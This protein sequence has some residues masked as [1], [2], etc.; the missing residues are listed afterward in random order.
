MKVTGNYLTFDFHVLFLA[1]QTNPNQSVF[2][3]REL[4]ANAGIPANVGYYGNN[5]RTEL[6]QDF[7][8]E[9]DQERKREREQLYHDDL[10]RLL[11]KYEQQEEDTMILADELQRNAIVEGAIMQQELK[12]RAN[13]PR[14]NV[15]WD[16]TTAE[17]GIEKRRLTLP[18]L[19][20]RR[21]RF[22]ISKRSPAIQ[23]KRD[24]DAAGA[25]ISQDL[26]TLFGEPSAD[27]KDRLGIHKVAKKSDRSV[28]SLH[29]SH[30]A[31]DEHSHEHSSHESHDHACENSEEDMDDDDRKKKRSTTTV[32]PTKP[33]I[34]GVN[35][36]REEL[37]LDQLITSPGS[38]V[39]GPSGLSGYDE[40]TRISKKSIQ[41]SKYFGLDR[42]KKSVD[43]WY[44]PPYR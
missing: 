41:W 6:A 8:R 4:E 29:H 39:P 2:R 7:V 14:F 22:P 1:D 27:T 31:S 26:Q 44:M 15:Q 43:E 18:W 28:E 9:I 21:K 11:S 33:N 13:H 37:K 38:S 19:P 25:K 24:T 40:V 20:A 5:P 23:G 10:Q 36:N 42:K 35:S 34:T 12:D 3:E 30:H 32:E 16:G 17:K